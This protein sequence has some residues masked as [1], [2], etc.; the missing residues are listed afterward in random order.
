MSERLMINTGTILW[1]P[2][3]AVSAEIIAMR[4]RA[5]AGTAALLL[6]PMLVIARP[7]W[8]V[9]GGAA[10]WP[11]CHCHPPAAQAQGCSEWSGHFHW[12]SWE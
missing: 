1:R 5:G 3:R 2:E 12:T 4:C 6:L 9:R 7:S 8:S 10:V 11:Y